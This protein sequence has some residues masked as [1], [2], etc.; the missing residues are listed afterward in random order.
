[1]TEMER[2]LSYRYAVA[3]A[4]KDATIRMLEAEISA[5]K[6]E[7]DRICEARVYWWKKYS[8]IAVPETK[9]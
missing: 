1:M 7:N 8:A 6:S 4:R 2:Q 5:L 9:L 3:L